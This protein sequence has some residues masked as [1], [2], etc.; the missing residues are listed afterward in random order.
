MA[1][2]IFWTLSVGIFLFFTLVTVELALHPYK[3]KN[4]LKSSYVFAVGVFLSAIL[5]YFPLN[6]NE[7]A[8]SQYPQLTAILASFHTAIRLF[9]V[10]CGFDM[11]KEMTMGLSGSIYNVYLYWA[12]AL[13][14][15]SPILTAGA[16]LSFISSISARIKYYRG[17]F[18]DAYIFSE[19]N[20]RSVT[21]AKDF[22]QNSSKRMVVFTDVYNTNDEV[23]YEL[24]ERA[25][26]IDA[27]IFKNSI[28]TVNFKFHSKK[29]KMYFFVIGADEIENINQASAL[30][31]PPQHDKRKL[32]GHHGYDYP[33][34]DTRL[35][36]FTNNFS[37]EQRIKNICPKHIKIRRVN[38]VQSLVYTLLNE[39]GLDIFNTSYITGD[40]VYNEATGQFDDEKK[41]SA[42][43]VGLGLHGT[44]MLKALSWFCQMPPYKLE[45]NAFDIQKNAASLFMS[46][47][48]ELFDINLAEESLGKDEKSKYHNGDFTTPGE[49]H[50]AISIHSGYDVKS[51]EFDEM[52][53]KIK[54]ATYVFVALGD[55]DL[56]I[57][58]STKIRVL[59]ERLAI[60]PTI[61]TV[62]YNPIKQNSIFEN[63]YDIF[64][65]G[66]IETNYTENCIL[67]SELESMALERHLQYSYKMIKIEESEKGPLPEDVKKVRIS[68]DTESFWRSDYNY[69]SSIASVLHTKMKKGLDLPGSKKPIPERTE[70][71]KRFYRIVEH[72]RWNAYVRSEGYVWA[73]KRNKLAK[74]HHLLVPFDKLDKAEQEKDDD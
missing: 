8:S 48:P 49:A 31:E 54:D 58:I 66:D 23:N 6:F 39:K 46:D 16:V 53:K 5:L 50:Y 2:W 7:F 37:S 59:Y 27:I 60:K 61:H 25:K 9:V 17:F 40:S 14:V 65:F 42:V 45:I 71:E 26:E 70:S 19:L 3:Q 69:R 64:T 73:E 11:I 41:I 33:A 20:E 52:L 55:D 57:K 44:E 51:F 24:I 67:N 1:Y 34:A 29:R 30:C 15:I 32:G 22:K 56:N 72:Q 74:T 18:K 36:L 13:M 47:C 28:T 63:V 35:F 43:I 21:L 62:I 68:E 12:A 10:D 38:D 4:L